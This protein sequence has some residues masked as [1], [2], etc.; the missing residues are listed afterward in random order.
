MLSLDR[1]AP[2]TRPRRRL[3][4]WRRAALALA[5]VLLLLTGSPAWAQPTSQ[6]GYQLI[7]TWWGTRELGSIVH[8]PRGP[9][10]SSCVAEL[11]L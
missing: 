10:L 3:P 7:P 1:P 8:V 4:W 2:A 9:S 6:Y 11:C 5:A